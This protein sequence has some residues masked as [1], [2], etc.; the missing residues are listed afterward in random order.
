MESDSESEA[1]FLMSYDSDLVESEV[2]KLDFG[3]R[4]WF[5]EV[6]EDEW[7]SSDSANDSLENSL[8]SEMF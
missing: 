5:S 2:D 1:A 7:E 4:D 8:S 3:E 6:E